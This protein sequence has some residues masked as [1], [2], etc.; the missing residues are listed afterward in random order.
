[1]TYYVRK[2]HHA[3]QA[4]I[5][6]AFLTIL[7]LRAARGGDLWTLMV[8]AAT[9]VFFLGIFDYALYKQ[10]GVPI[11]ETSKSGITINNV[12][13]SR[14]SLSWD[15]V[16]GLERSRLSGYKLVTLGE[17]VWLPVGMLTPQDRDRLLRDISTHLPT[18][19]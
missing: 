13:R 2:L 15:M 14:E 5:P 8:G 1:M 7:A 19:A 12:W 11:F 18:P 6:A 9:A 16:V 10:V 4:M 17:G 3:A